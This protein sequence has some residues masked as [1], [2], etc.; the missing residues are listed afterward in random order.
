MS[1]VSFYEQLISFWKFNLSQIS[2]VFLWLPVLS[3]LLSCLSCRTSWIL[4]AYTLATVTNNSLTSLTLSTTSWSLSVNNSNKVLCFFV[5]R[6]FLLDLQLVIILRSF[7]ILCRLNTRNW[8]TSPLIHFI[9]QV[10]FSTIHL[11]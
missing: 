2:C 7:L 9:T 11:E 1:C 5:W 10:L 8:F 4:G 6:L 3:T